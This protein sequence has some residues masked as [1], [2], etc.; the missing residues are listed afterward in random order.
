MTPVLSVAERVVIDTVREVEVGGMVKEE[1]EGAVE[2]E[3]GETTVGLGSFRYMTE[4][5]GSIVIL[6]VCLT[7]SISTTGHGR[8]TVLEDSVAL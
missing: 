4:R 1:M 3:G 5:Y 2:S 7:P 8:E 6:P